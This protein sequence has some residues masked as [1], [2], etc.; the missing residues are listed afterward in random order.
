MGT[1]LE[2]YIETEL[3]RIL[4]LLNSDN[5]TDLV[6]FLLSPENQERRQLGT[7][8]VSRGWPTDILSNVLHDSNFQDFYIASYFVE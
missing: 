2:P 6:S 8:A 7:Y 5:S 1:R 4:L 3:Q